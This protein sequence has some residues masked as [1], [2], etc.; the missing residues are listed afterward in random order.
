MNLLSA[1][2][3]GLLPLSV[4]K[5]TSSAMP[6]DPKNTTMIF[7]GPTAKTA[8]HAALAKAQEMKAQ[9]ASRADI[10]RETGW[11]LE[12]PDQIPRFEIDDSDAAL[13]NVQRFPSNPES[14]FGDAPGGTFTDINHPRFVDAYGPTPRIEGEY[15]PLKSVSGQYDPVTGK[16]F[17]KGPTEDRALSTSLHEL[18]HSVQG[19][20]GF[21]AGASPDEFANIDFQAVEDGQLFHIL[22]AKHGLSPQEAAVKLETHTG[23]PLS[24][25]ALQIGMSDDAMMWPGSAEEAYMRHA[26]EVEARNVQSR[27]NMTA[28]ER[29]ATPPWETQD[30]PDDQQIVRFK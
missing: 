9:G 25:E 12:Q 30:V 29:R 3:G 4:Q 26:G 14:L 2:A 23:R 8:D 15:G 24:Q 13:R 22:M 17:A 27:M 21:G 7:A 1:L 5:L 28:A 20:E 18:Q 11:D 6:S 19:R 16:I 10:W